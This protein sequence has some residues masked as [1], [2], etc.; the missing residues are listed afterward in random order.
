MIWVEDVE[1]HGE[2]LLDCVCQHAGADACRFKVTNH[3]VLF[4]AAADLVTENFLHGDH[5]LLPCR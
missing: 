1:R 4:V 5:G 3:T 2:P